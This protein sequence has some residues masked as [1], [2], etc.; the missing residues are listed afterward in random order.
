M[1]YKIISLSKDKL[2][3]NIDRLLKTYKIVSI[4]TPGDE[5][6]Y[7]YVLQNQRG[8]YVSQSLFIIIESDGT[9]NVDEFFP[10]LNH[11]KK[12]NSKNKGLSSALFYL[13]LA[14]V[15][16]NESLPTGTKVRLRSKIDALHFYHRMEGFG[17]EVT[18]R[19]EKSRHP[20]WITGR[21]VNFDLSG[22]YTEQIGNTT[23]RNYL[24]QKSVSF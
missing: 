12:A 22:T 13:L 15:A 8:E 16:N 1:F 5:D 11:P 18:E 6:I 20:S 9:I 2:I 4:G 3:N 23:S 14:H 24:R 17:F 10:N 7:S 21:L 19:G